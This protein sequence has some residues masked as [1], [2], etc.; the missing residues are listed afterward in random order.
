MSNY[1]APT[2]HP[3]TGAIEDAVWMDDYFGPHRYGVRFG[4]GTVH[5]ASDCEQV[6]PK[7]MAEISRLR[8][9]E[10]AARTCVTRDFD[11]A[12]CQTLVHFLAASPSGGAE[13]EA[14]LC[15][16]C[17]D[18]LAVCSISRRAVDCPMRSDQRNKQSTGEK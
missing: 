1:T 16:V 10:A 9:I 6:G 4:D 7:A 12:G 15:P 2:F 3:V 17:C 18:D 5:A 13:Q 8:C 11:G 14:P